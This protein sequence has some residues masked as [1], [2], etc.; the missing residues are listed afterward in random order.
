[1]FAMLEGVRPERDG[2]GFVVRRLIRRA[3]RQ[4][5]LLGLNQPFLYT[6]VQPLEQAH[7]TLITPEERQRIPLVT[8]MTEDEERRFERVLTIGLKYLARLEP[9]E[10]GRIP[11]QSLFDLHAEKGFPADLAAE[12]LAERGLSVD[13]PSYETAQE[14]HRRVS[15]LSAERHFGER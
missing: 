10:S 2:C 7:G 1:M 12:I 4:G 3:A 5:R 14:E 6:L 15:R 8:Q 13:W 11:G 9:G